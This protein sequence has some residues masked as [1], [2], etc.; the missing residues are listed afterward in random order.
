MTDKPRSDLGTYELRVHG[1]LGP[2]LLSALPHVAAQTVPR[3]TKL[4]TDGSKGRDVVEIVQLIVDT[5][6]DVVSVR[7]VPS[8]HDDQRSDE[9]STGS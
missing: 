1:L 5:G 3:H 7:G 2:C 4:V 9:R 8:Q 6:V